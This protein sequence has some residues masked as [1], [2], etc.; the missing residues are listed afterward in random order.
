MQYEMRGGDIQTKIK[1]C[2]YCGRFFKVHS[3]I[4]KTRIVKRV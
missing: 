4:N 3:N 1:R 2:V